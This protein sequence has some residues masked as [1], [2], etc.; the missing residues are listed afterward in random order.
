MSDDGPSAEG[1]PREQELLREN[2][3]LR[4]RIAELESRIDA[5]RGAVRASEPSVE[6]GP[7]SVPPEASARSDPSPAVTAGDRK[8]PSL[9]QWIGRIVVP[10]VGAV[11]VLA[12]VGFLVHYAIEIGII[13][14]IPAVG[15]F[16]LGILLGVALLAA[17]EF[18]RRRGAPG[19]AVGLDAAGVGSVMITTALGVFSLKLFDGAVAAWIAGFALIV[20]A[21][22]SVRSGSAVVAIVA[23]IGCFVM[24]P[25]VGV[26]SSDPFA[27]SLV[28][29]LAL[30]TGLAT[31]LFGGPRFESAR[32]VALLSAIVLG[33]PVLANLDGP[34]RV[35]CAALVWWGLAVAEALLSAQRGFNARG[36]ALSAAVASI[37]LVLVEVG[38]WTAGVGGWNAVDFLPSLAGA[39]LFAGSLLLRTTAFEPADDEERAALDQSA[40]AIGGACTMLARVYGALA[41]A[42]GVGGVAFL[43]NDSARAIAVCA[44][45]IVAAAISRR[46]KSLPFELISV[47]LGLIGAV[48]AVVVFAINAGGRGAVWEFALP[49]VAGSRFEFSWSA[50]SLGLLA[51]TALLLA[52][53][54]LLRVR[55]S[56]LF[57]VLPVVVVW[58]VF[59]FGTI[60][61]VGGCALLALPAACILFAR[62]AGVESVA[63]TLVLCVFAVV[64]WTVIALDRDWWVAS[65]D[66]GELAWVVSAWSACALLCAHHRALVAIR[67]MLVVGVIGLA[68]IGVA[69]SAGVASTGRGVGGIDAAYASIIALA[70]AAIAAGIA[71][72]V[73]R[74]QGVRDGAAVLGLESVALVVILGLRRLF[75]SGSVDDDAVPVALEFGAIAASITALAVLS[76]LDRGAEAKTRV[77]PFA[78]FAC[79]FA[80]APA[81]ALVL[82]IAAGRP[83]PAVVAVG[84]FAVV[85]VAELVIGFRRQIAVLRWAGLGCF[86]LLVVRL[87]A[88][89][90]AEAP[91]L[92]RI[93]LL[94]VSGMVLV[95]T[96]IAYARIARSTS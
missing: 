47:L 46:E 53:M 35:V 67:D 19:A 13:G 56:R 3:A 51:S 89:D 36:N 84:C 20:A 68:G 22:W 83:L 55:A 77:L 34:V 71:A 12:A 33:I 72:R 5:A 21:A 9:E 74:S 30:A 31:H 25:G 81:A 61:D 59:S 23:L 88:V 44:A 45:A 26:V 86:G 66:A 82:A 18:V 58:G 85:G 16:T 17:G 70:A 69:V 62:R 73:S 43:V 48:T 6:H 92:V 90:L 39:L 87:Y 91:L 79:A 78:L 4:A 38:S 65:G 94:F 37:A 63:A 10:F 1:S 80:A 96:G 11:A 2:A 41:L 95:G 40:L 14:R 28:V 15:R 75:E 76:A 60:D 7:G 42:L 49:F 64:P 27:A 50:G 8:A 24:P 52:T 93:G 32:W 54:S 29:A 57:L